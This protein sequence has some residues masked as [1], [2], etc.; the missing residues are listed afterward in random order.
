MRET[1]RDT[2]SSFRKLQKNPKEECHLDWSGGD[3]AS[4]EDGWVVERTARLSDKRG[5]EQTAD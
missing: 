3:T 2:D 5:R 4:G 1:S